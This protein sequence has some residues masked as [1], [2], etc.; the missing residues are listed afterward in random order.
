MRESQHYATSTYNSSEEPLIALALA[1]KLKSET[2]HFYI[3]NFYREVPYEM[4]EP[5]VVSFT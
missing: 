4:A 3:P 5:F 2:C 1:N